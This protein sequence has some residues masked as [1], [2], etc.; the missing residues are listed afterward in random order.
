MR[1]E[2]VLT[3]TFRLN[4]FRVPGNIKNPFPAQ[5]FFLLNSLLFTSYKMKIVA[6][7]R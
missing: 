4:I 2:L 6:L 3:I 1:N 7:V 5:Q